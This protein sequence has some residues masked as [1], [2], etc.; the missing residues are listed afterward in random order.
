MTEATPARKDSHLIEWLIWSILALTIVAVGAA[1]VWSKLAERLDK[2]LFVAT[3]V[4]EF[5]LTN[6]LGEVISLSN[7]LGHV[8]VADVIFTR[9]PI[10]CEK[11]SKRMR[12]LQDEL[13]PRT[14]VRFISLTADPGYDSPEILRKYSERHGA[15]P[16]RWH[17]L[18]GLKRAVYG[19]AIDGLKLAVVDKTDQ[20]E[21]P[22]DLFI[23]ST[24]F[25]LVDKRGRIRGTFEGT[26][27]HERQQ[28]AI[29]VRKLAREH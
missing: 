8:V 19:L 12:V 28:L 11:M 27:D 22:D 18:T 5:S 20:K 4:P 26:D 29:A 7:L 16:S 13:G 14:N 17:F 1:F 9:C 3:S 25:V 15:D 10:S 24:Q 21:T 6:Q 23:H 2:P